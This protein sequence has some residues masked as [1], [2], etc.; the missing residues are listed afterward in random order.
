[1]DLDVSR[2]KF[3]RE[4]DYLL[5]QA[6][7]FV[8]ASG[9]EALQIEYPVVSA[10]FVH[11]RSGRRVGFRFLC[12]N[13]DEMPPALV[14]FDSETNEEL[15]WAKW[16]KGNWPVGEAHP[17][18][19]RPFLCL[20]G[21]REYHTHSSHLNDTWDNL[22]GKETYGLRYILYRVQQRFGNSDG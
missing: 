22:R 1:M 10:V 15:S 13:W 19:S 11:P 17:A 7:D 5:T 14:L 2:R 3:A 8:V 6:R 16:P 12:D 21:I 20:P 18:T 9:W 4:C